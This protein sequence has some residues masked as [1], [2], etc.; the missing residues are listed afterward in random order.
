MFIARNHLVDEAIK[1]AVVGDISSF[2]KL[3]EILKTP[4]KYRD[5]LEEFMQPPSPNFEECFQTYCGT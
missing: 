3:L 2:N 1:K 5:G 4:Y